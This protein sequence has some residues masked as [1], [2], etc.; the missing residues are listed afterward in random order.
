MI[1]IFTSLSFMSMLSLYRINLVETTDVLKRNL[2][3]LLCLILSLFPVSAISEQS[4]FSVEDVVDSTLEELLDISASIASSKPEL[5]PNTPAVVSTYYT[6]DLRKM[7]VRNLKELLSSIPGISVINSYGSTVV[8]VRGIYEAFNHKV[9]LLINDV[10][11]F[12]PSH[13]DIPMQGIPME[14]IVRVEVIRG[15]GAVYHGN[16]AS[17]G[18]INI[19]TKNE[20]GADLSIAADTNGLINH[21]GYIHHDLG[22]KH[23]FSV[24]YEIQ[25]GEAYEG[26]TSGA[27][28]ATSF[29]SQTGL[30]D[31][32]KIGLG[33]RRTS[34][35]FRYNNQDT[36]IMYQLFESDLGGL[37]GNQTVFSDSNIEHHGSLFHINRKVNQDNFQAN[38]YADYNQ[39]YLKLLV[40]NQAGIA[41][42]GKYQFHNDGAASYRW[43]A[44]GDLTL[45]LGKQ[46]S[47]FLLHEIEKRSTSSYQFF[48][49]DT[50]TKILDLMSSQSLFERSFSAQLDFNLEKLR[51]L[52]GARYTNN[53]VSGEKTTPRFSAIYS[54]NDSQSLK[55]LYAEGFN[56]PSFLQQ[57]LTV[58]PLLTGNPDLEAESIRTTDLVYTHHKNDSLFV[59]NAYYMEAHDFIER[60]INSG[61]IT[62]QNSRVFY[63]YGLELDYQRKRKRNTIFANLG[64][65]QSGN[66]TIANDPLTKLVPRATAVL[67]IS[68]DINHQDTVGFSVQSMSARNGLDPLYLANLHAQ[69]KIGD[70]ELSATIKNIFD[71]S[72]LQPDLSN[73]KRGSYLESGPGVSLVIGARATFK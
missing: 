32:G 72:T 17:S 55:L 15:P 20:S 21:N 54:I 48:N 36:H 40:D 31:S 35:L 39:Y 53:E 9:L 29:P 24:S 45:E 14:S 33:E 37:V 2:K 65:V 43:R 23:S 42:P 63:R 58:P 41:V 61:V 12:M 52:V 68:Y 26:F 13:S 8:S 5:I 3:N 38:V 1:P 4:D 62:F 67:G 71:E 44:G 30:P 27:P 11:Y 18:V 19:I 47:L 60:V 7:G 70:I 56:A 59:A 49:V 10:P 50:D 64:L 22:E 66:E 57:Y 51:F 28:T 16:K 34:A 46:V 6:A 73:L 25:E 69:R